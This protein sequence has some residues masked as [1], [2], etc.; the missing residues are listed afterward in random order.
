VEVEAE[1]PAEE[2]GPAED[3]E[4][5]PAEDAEMEEDPFAEIG[6]E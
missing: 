2:A 4:E 6:E 5:A 1:A 3:R